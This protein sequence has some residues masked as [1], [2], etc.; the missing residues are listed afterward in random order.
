[1]WTMVKSALYPDSDS[2]RCTP[3][4]CTAQHPLSAQHLLCMHKSSSM[5][6]ALQVLSGGA[7]IGRCTHTPPH[8]CGGVV[9]SCDCVRGSRALHLAASVRQTSCSVVRHWLC[10]VR[11]QV[12]LTLFLAI[13]DLLVATFLTYHTALIA[14]G[15][16]TYEVVRRD[17]AL[18]VLGAGTKPRSHEHAAGAWGGRGVDARHEADHASSNMSF[19]DAAKGHM[20]EAGGSLGRGGAVQGQTAAAQL[21]RTSAHISAVRSCPFDRG[22]WRNFAEVLFPGHALHVAALQHSKVS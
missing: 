20:A 8:L 3:R 18:S 5:Q 17:Q 6:L 10:Y 2:M 14:A 4:P 21:S 7:R 9:R 16:T 11:A 15:L 12:T 13:A 22:V 19:K 1:M